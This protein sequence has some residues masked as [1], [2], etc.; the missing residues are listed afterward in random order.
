MYKQG[1]NGT[2]LR[3]LEPDESK[4]ALAEVH[5]GIYGSHLKGLTLA[6]KLI[7]VGYYWPDME[8]EAFQYAKTCK[9]YQ[10]HGNL[11]HALAK[12]LIPFISFW[13]FQQWAFDFLGQIHP[14]SSRGH[15]FI[16]TATD[17]FTKWVE[18]VPLAIADGKSMAMFILNYI[19]CRYG[20][21]SSIITDN[22][23]QFKNKDLRELC[24]KFRII[25]HWSSIY[26]P[27]GNGQAEASNKTTVKILYITVH[28]S[29]RDW[30]L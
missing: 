13:P 11:T 14:S 3:C 29:G 9:Q 7:R 2:L 18:A 24:T 5:E 15:K 4:R 27:Q 30:H 26:Y 25:Q 23:G 10:F 19:I 16:I 21:P 12:E 17:Y 1:L 28:K 22:G 20:V 8:K 6:H